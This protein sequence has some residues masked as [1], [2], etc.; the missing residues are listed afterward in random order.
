MRWSTGVCLLSWWFKVQSQRILHNKICYIWNINCLLWAW[1]TA[2][3]FSS[4][5]HMYFIMHGQIKLSFISSILINIDKLE[6]EWC[7]ENFCYYVKIPTRLDNTLFN[8]IIINSFKVESTSII[9]NVVVFRECV[10]YVVFSW[11]SLK[12]SVVRIM[13]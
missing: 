12:A 9:H 1:H 13:E 3:I 8:I 4:I 7:F 5:T 11:C 6:H 10:L 2:F